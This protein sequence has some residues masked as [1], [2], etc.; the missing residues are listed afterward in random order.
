MKFKYRNIFIKYRYLA[1]FLTPL[2]IYYDIFILTAPLNFVMIL[3]VVL[4]TLSGW[5]FEISGRVS[6]G[7]AIG[8]LL[9]LPVLLI[10]NKDNLAERLTF[11]V[12]IFMTIGV[13]QIYIREVI[14]KNND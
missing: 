6:I 8:G 12:F 14:Y 7:V 13:I 5:I 11:W 3:A 9:L 10:S 4:W 2:V 1:L